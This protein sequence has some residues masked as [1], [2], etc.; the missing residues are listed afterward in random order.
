MLRK[1]ICTLAGG[2]ALVVPL[3]G[4]STVQAQ[5]PIVVVTPAAY[6]HHRYFVEFRPGRHSAWSVSGPYHSQRHAHEVARGLR[7]QGFHTR[8]VQR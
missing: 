7:S 5:N 4:V 3:A 2:L 6:H 8:V 1:L